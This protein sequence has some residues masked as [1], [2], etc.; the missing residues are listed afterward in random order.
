MLLTDT[1]LVFGIII[2][3]I[4]IVW[5]R[6]MDQRMYDTVMEIKDILS[7]VKK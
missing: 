2:F 5:S 3:I 4:L 7:G 1:L 6:V